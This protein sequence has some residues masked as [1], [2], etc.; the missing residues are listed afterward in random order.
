MAYM[1]FFRAW[2]LVVT[3]WAAALSVQAQWYTPFVPGLGTD[4][5]PESG[6]RYWGAVVIGTGSLTFGQGLGGSAVTVASPSHKTFSINSQTKTGQF[7]VI[8]GYSNRSSDT[9]SDSSFRF[10]PQGSVIAGSGS[11]DNA[12]RTD[13]QSPSGGI[14][15]PETFDWNSHPRT[16]FGTG[17]PVDPDGTVHEP[18]PTETIQDHKI[19]FTLSNPGSTPKDFYIQPTDM[20]GNPLPDL[21]F[22]K[23]TLAPGESRPFAFSRPGTG[24]GGAG[25]AFKVSVIQTDWVSDPEFGVVKQESLTGTWNSVPHVV[26]INDAVEGGA[27]TGEGGPGSTPN[28]PPAQQDDIAGGDPL[29]ASQ[30]NT[31]NRNT[32][33]ELQRLGATVKSAGDVAH[34]DAQQILNKLGG[35]GGADMSGVEGKLD[36]VKDAIEGVKNAVEGLGSNEPGDGS[37]PLTG[38]G[39]PSLPADGIDEAQEATGILGGVPEKLDVMKGRIGLVVLKFNSVKNAMPAGGGSQL[40]DFSVQTAFGPMDFNFTAYQDTFTVIRF[41]CL[42][43]VYW[44]AAWTALQLIRGALV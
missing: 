35:L 36:G 27:P 40:L 1:S 10:Y 6:N 5:M 15:D 16:E 3:L 19:G 20:Q 8:W 21:P 34:S 41:A 12:V 29:T 31:L 4:P 11:A 24:A 26:P 43:V 38:P 17:N 39:P 2:P 42:L 9:G 13:I 14:A 18:P 37:G 30:A 25:G 44:N 32:L 7:E 22:Q 23:V 33:N 28:Q